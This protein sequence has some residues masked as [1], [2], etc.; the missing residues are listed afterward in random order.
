[1][2]QIAV[3]QQVRVALSIGNNCGAKFR[4]HIGAILVVGDFAKALSLTL[5]AIH[6]AGTIQA[7]Q[8]G[9]FL[10]TNFRDDLN[11]VLVLKTEVCLCARGLLILV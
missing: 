8:R 4:Q 7:F 9:I 1:M 6:T 3:R 10:G 5:G 2:H 11:L